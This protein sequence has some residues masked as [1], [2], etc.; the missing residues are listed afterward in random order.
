M[1]DFKK[2][3]VINQNDDELFDQLYEN[4]LKGFNNAYVPFSHF[5]VG[6]SLLLDDGTIVYGCNVEN[7]SYGLCNCAE[8]TTLFK[9][10]SM[11]YRQENIKAF[12]VIGDTKRPVSPCGACRQVMSELMKLDTIVYLT[13]LDRLTVKVTVQDLLPY[14]FSGED[15]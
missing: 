14:N 4:A 6:A 12:L 8:R 7:S 15:L 11:G 1:S 9:T 13:N 2:Q 10:Y 3:E 5:K